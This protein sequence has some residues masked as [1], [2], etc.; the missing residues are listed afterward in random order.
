MSSTEDET[1]NNI[2]AILTGGDVG[3][4]A[5]D[6][7]ISCIKRY[8]ARAQAELGKKTIVYISDVDAIED[9][10]FS[11]FCQFVANEAANEFGGTTDF[12]KKKYLEN[13]LRE[14]NRQTPGYNHQ[15]VEY[16]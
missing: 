13:E 12:K 15:Q 9:E 6:E 11:N 10:I 7:D 5:S 1:A 4:V 16:F 14:I 2:Y 3:A 8:I